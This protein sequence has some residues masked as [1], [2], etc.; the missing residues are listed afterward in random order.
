LGGCCGEL[1]GGCY[2]QCDELIVHDSGAPV[3][4]V[5]DGDGARGGTADDVTT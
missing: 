2:Q 4:L 3:L 1:Q 5:N